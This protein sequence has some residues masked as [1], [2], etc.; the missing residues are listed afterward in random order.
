MKFC[1]DDIGDTILVVLRV[2]NVDVQS[3][4][5]ALDYS[6]DH[7]NDCMVRVIVEDKV[8]PTCNAPANKTVS[9]ENFDPSLW[10]YGAATAT[11][12]C[13]IDT[14]TATANY[15][16]FDTLCNRGTITRTFR[17]LDCGGL[18]STCTQRVLVTLARLFHPFSGRSS[19]D[20]L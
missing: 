14:I 11:D 1:C 18:S 5:V 3:G 12:N 10:A 19:G 13:C 6:E 7:A 15:S 4:D 2:Y 8:K 16:Q 9:C 20:G 17:A